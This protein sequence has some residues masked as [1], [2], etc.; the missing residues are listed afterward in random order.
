MVTTTSVLQAN[1]ATLLKR[2]Q[3][4]TNGIIEQK[5]VWNNDGT[6]KT[7]KLAPPSLL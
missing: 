6:V 3:E 7:E 5:V 2:K 1:L 4:Y